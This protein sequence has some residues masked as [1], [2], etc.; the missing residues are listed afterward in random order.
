MLAAL[1]VCIVTV[2]VVRA[3]DG[4]GGRW[5]VRAYID[6]GTGSLILQALI[7]SLIG[8]VYLVRNSWRNIKGYF[9]RL[10]HIKIEKD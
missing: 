1:L 9:L 4:S 3:C 8:V 10:L 5:G 6:P 7:A 2:T